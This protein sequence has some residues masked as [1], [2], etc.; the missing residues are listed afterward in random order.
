MFKIILLYFQ[1]LG[2][3]LV[4]IGIWTAAEKLYVSHVIGDK[5]FGA[6]SYL[7]IAVGIFIILVCIVGII[8]LWKDKRKLLVAVSKLS[9]IVI[10]C[11]I[12]CLILVFI[13]KR[14][15]ISGNK[16]N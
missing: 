10:N 11:I 3:T 8:A 6:A 13:K 1:I 4:G 14:L 16:L 5:L 9:H 7:I 12:K 2:I 15:Y